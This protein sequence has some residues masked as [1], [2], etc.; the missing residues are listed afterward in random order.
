MEGMGNVERE[1]WTEN[2]LAELRRQL[3]QFWADLWFLQFHIPLT[4]CTSS[5]VIF[6]IALPFPPLSAL[7]GNI[8]WQEGHRFHPHIVLLD[9]YAKLLAEPVDGQGERHVEGV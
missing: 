2:L 8:D 1:G 9:P 5:Y 6:I 4:S 7:Q 3:I